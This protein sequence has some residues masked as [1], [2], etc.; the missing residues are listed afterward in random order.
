MLHRKWYILCVLLCIHSVSPLNLRVKKR[1]D[2]TFDQV[3]PDAFQPAPTSSPSLPSH[4]TAF[5]L[6]SVAREGL[7]GAFA[8]SIQ[9]IL[10]MWLRTTMSYQHKYGLSLRNTIRDLY[11][12]GGI[13]RFYK[14]V[15]FAMIQ[16]PLAKF[17]S[18]NFAQ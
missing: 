14:G 6:V 5:S 7:S 15:E 10:L 17:F 9:V 2:A 13:R 8:G 16:A 3:H 18:G 1:F 12:Q 11:K 4:S